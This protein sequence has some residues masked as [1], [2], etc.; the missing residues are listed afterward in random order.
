[1]STTLARRDRRFRVVGG[2]RIAAELDAVRAFREGALAAH[3][4]AGT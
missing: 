1:L 3:E 4:L 2:A